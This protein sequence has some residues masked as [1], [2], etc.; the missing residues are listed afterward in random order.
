MRGRSYIPSP[1]QSPPRGHGRRGR[2]PSPSPRGGGRYRA[3]SRDLRTSL[4]VRQLSRDC[5][6]GDLRKSF[7]QFGPLKDIHLPTDHRTGGCH[8]ANCSSTEACVVKWLHLRGK[9]DMIGGGG[10]THAHPPA[11]AQGVAVQVQPQEKKE[12]HLYQRAETGVGDLREEGATHLYHQREAAAHV[13]SN[14][15]TVHQASD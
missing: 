6:E 14:R 9:K 1:S 12:Q 3:R 11:M 15:K 5:R 2:S 10:P 8:I 7:K 4:F 13:G